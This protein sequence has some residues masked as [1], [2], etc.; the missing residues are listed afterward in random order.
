MR[1]VQAVY[2]RAKSVIS[3]FSAL[4]Y[5]SF[6]GGVILF[7]VGL[8]IG[9]PWGHLTQGGQYVGALPISGRLIA[10]VSIILLV[11]FAYSV[12]SKQTKW[13]PHWPA[14]TGWATLVVQGISMLLNWITPSQSE[15]YLWGP[16]TTLM[17]VLVVISLI[18]AGES[19]DE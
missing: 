9:L 6:C 11:L 19:R 14:W 7:Q 4:L 1:R 15:R 16:I 2:S 10:G 17:F 8:I 5:A 12:M 3:R 18:S 13:L